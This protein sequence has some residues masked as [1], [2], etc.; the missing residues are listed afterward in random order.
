MDTDS[1]S[2][3]DKNCNH[4][5]HNRNTGAGSAVYGLGMIGAWIFYIGHAT[6]FWIGVLGFLK[7][8]VWPAFVVFG[9]LNYLH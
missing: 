2:M 5:H 4:H 1:N 7:G 9:L 6:T 3:T 8:I